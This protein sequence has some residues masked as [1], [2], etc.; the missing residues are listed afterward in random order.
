[1]YSFLLYFWDSDFKLEREIYGRIKL[2]K[3]PELDKSCR[4]LYDFLNLFI[5]AIKWF[6]LSETAFFLLNE[7]FL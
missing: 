4:D 3:R 7:E 2:R 6:H 5:I 1:M